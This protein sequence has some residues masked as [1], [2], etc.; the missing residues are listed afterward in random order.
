MREEVH[1][2]RWESP[3][4]RKGYS[5]KKGARQQVLDLLEFEC[6]PTFVAGL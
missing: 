1:Y 2:L 5:P 3:G 6:R 4:G